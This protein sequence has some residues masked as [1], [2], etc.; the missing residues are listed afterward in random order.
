MAHNPLW[1]IQYFQQTHQIP[2]QALPASHI[3][4]HSPFGDVSS[5]LASLFAAAV[6]VKWA[7][8]VWETKRLGQ[9]V[10]WKTRLWEFLLF[11]LTI[12]IERFFSE[13]LHRK[14]QP[15]GIIYPREDKI[16]GERIPQ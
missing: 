3:S 15:V 8:V 2:I 10:A 9:G 14:I 12:I 16:R 7:A 6:S 11:L 1:S 4:L 5:I 13:E